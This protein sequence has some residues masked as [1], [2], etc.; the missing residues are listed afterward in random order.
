MTKVYEK[1]NE[2]KHEV[3]AILKSR[4]AKIPISATVF[5]FKNAI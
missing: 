1:A 3:A 4:K 5:L 2:I